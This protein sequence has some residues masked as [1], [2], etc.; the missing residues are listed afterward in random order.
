MRSVPHGVGVDVGVAANGNEVLGGL[1]QPGA[2][3]LY[4]GR[5]SAGVFL[6]ADCALGVEDGALYDREPKGLICH[7]EPLPEW[8]QATDYKQ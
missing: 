3:L 2:G 7:V 4:Q 8:Q 1:E 5:S 6:A